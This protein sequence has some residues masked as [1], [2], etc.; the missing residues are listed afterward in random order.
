[1]EQN[2]LDYTIG[3]QAAEAY[4]RFRRAV[5]C[6]D[7]WR[8][9]GQRTASHTADLNG[10]TVETL[11][12]LAWLGPCG[13]NVRLSQRVDGQQV[14]VGTAQPLDGLLENC[15]KALGLGE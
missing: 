6:P 1:M 2:E 13:L 8:R 15:R 4:E 12:I 7:F 9:L 14:S 3:S 5:Q 10:H 11:A